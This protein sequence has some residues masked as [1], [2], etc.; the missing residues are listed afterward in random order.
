MDSGTVTSQMASRVE[1][2]ATLSAKATFLLLA[3]I[4]SPS[5]LDLLRQR[6]SIRF[7]RRSGASHR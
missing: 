5:S 7:M 4:P 1:S 3:S 6:L 2:G